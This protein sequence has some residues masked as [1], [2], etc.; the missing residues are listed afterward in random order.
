MARRR[1]E[2]VDALLEIK[3][4]GVR[5]AEELGEIFLEAIRAR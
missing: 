5:K 1:P 2:S 3:G 4:V